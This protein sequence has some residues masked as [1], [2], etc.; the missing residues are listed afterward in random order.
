M[1]E[2][3]SFKPEFISTFKSVPNES[4]LTIKKLTPV[5]L[6][7]KTKRGKK[8]ENKLMMYIIKRGD[9]GMDMDPLSCAVPNVVEFGPDWRAGIIN[10]DVI[11]CFFSPTVIEDEQEMVGL[12]SFKP[13]F[14]STFKSV[15]NESLLTIKKLTP[16]LLSAK[17]KRGK[18]NENKLMMYIIKRG[19]FGM[20]MDPLSCAVPN[21]VEFGPDWR[22]GII[23]GDVIF[24]FF[25]PTVIEDEQEMVGLV[26]FKPE[27]IS[28][29]KSVPNE[30]LLTIKKLTPVLLSAKTKRG[31]KNENKLMMYIIKRGDFGMDM[32]PLSCAVPNVVEF[33]PDWRAGIINGDVI[34]CFFSPTVIED[35]QEMVGLVSFKPEFISTFKSVPNE[36]LLTIKVLRQTKQDT[37]TDGY[38]VARVNRLRTK[39]TPVLLSAKTKRGKK[40]ENKLMMYIIKR[41][42]FGMDMDPLSCAVPNVVEFGPDWRAGIIN[43]D[44]IFCFFS[45]TVIE[46]EQEMVGLVSFKPEFIS[47]FKSV[48]NESLLTIKKLTPVLLSAKT[49]R[50]KKNENKLM[51]Y[52]IKRGDFGMDM[53]PL[54]CA[55]PNV[56]EFG[57]D[58]R[59][60]IINGDVIFCFFSPTVIEDEQEMVGLVSFKPE[61]ISTFKS[62]P[63]E[64]LLTIKKLTPV[65]LSAKTKRGKKNENKLMMYIIK[66]GDFGMDMDP[67]SCAVPNVVEFGPDWRAG[68]INGD[69]IFCFFSP[70]VIEDEQ[71]MVGLVSFKPEFISTFKSVPNESLLTIKKL[72]PVLLSAKTKRGKK[73]ENKLM[74]Y[75]IKRGD[76]GMDMDPLSCAVPN[77]VEFGPDWRAGIINGDVIFCFFSP[78][79]IED[80]Q[81]MVGL[82]SFKPEFISTFKSVPNESLLT[83]KKLTPVLLSAKTKRGKKNENKLMMYIIKRGD[84]GMDMD[85][86]SCAV[87]NVV[88]F[89]PDWRAGIIN[90]DVIFCFFSPTVIEDEQEM[91]GLVSFKP[92]FISTFK[93]VP[94]ESLLTIKKLTPVLLSAK[95]KRGKKNENKL[96][97]YIIKRGDFGMDMD[98]LSCAVPNVVEFGPDWRAGIINGDVIF[99]FFS[100]TVIEDEQ[101]MVGLVSFKP[102]FIS[103][104]KS[105]P[106]ESLLTIK[107]LR[108]T[109]QDTPTDGY[110]VARVNR[111]RT[112]KTKAAKLSQILTLQKENSHR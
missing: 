99:C 102:E 51:M 109:K 12:V 3:V 97:M 72:T 83:I 2:L 54:S 48:P 85:P 87:P 65:L 19:D 73:N 46:D 30:S 112:V 50:G 41:G 6:S 75:I 31:K 27:F 11:F 106:N 105:V 103:T 76:F 80:E 9:F 22:A 43:G 96:M 14:I 111:L 60:G 39:L 92:E 95:T 101:E 40:N 98:P 13:E 53:D 5:L 34:F 49:K 18:K 35:E 69:V 7:A 86:L 47:T 16:V 15:P 77:V 79:V 78:T 57:P 89:G 108:Q 29:F 38:H 88:E 74:M 1:V 17:T 82:V 24:C 100:P 23:N 33:G 25:S 26:S 8:N 36:S 63:N 56:V 4:L 93:S 58:W 55:V 44:V 107:V 42:D 104:F 52:I 21:V 67:L 94:N 110:H 28:T 37:P 84:F 70:T 90:G 64:S 10:G 68:I 66:R 45:P 59:A 71:E 32:D 20:D 81:E 91:V 62:V 61:F